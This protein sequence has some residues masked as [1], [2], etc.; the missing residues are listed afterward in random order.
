MNIR[1]HWLLRRNRGADS[2]AANVAW[3]G[4]GG[5][6]D[7]GWFIAV[8]CSVLQSVAVFGS[9]VCC[10]VLQC[11]P[12]L[13]QP[14]TAPDLDAVE[15]LIAGEI[16]QCVVAFCS[17]AA[18]CSVLQCSVLHCV[19][20]LAQPTTAPDLDAVEVL[21]RVRC[22]SVLQCV[23]MCCS[24]LQCVAMCCSVLQCSMLQCVAVRTESLPAYNCAW[25]GCGGG[26]DLGWDAAAC[27]S[28]LQRAVACCSVLQCVAVCYSAVCCS[29]LHCVPSI[30]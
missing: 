14:T 21:T 20:S 26:L 30:A 24:V 8:C 9:A 27:C 11:V 2:L 5:G 15:V 23:A 18:C 7:F 3:S 1:V 25:S 29:V 16:L 19:P 13:A 12:S 6:F 4:R 17:V 28:V 22:S 10:S